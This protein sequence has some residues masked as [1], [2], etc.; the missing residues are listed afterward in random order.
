MSL[1]SK[2]QITSSVMEHLRLKLFFFYFKFCSNN[3]VDISFTRLLN[4][5]M[6]DLTTLIPQRKPR[7]G[8]II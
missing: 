7:T 6:A 2:T 1:D 3:C 4:S 5:P 8:Q